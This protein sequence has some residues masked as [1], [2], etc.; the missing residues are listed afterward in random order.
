MIVSEKEISELSRG[1]KAQLLQWLVKD[2][3]GNFAF[4]LD[5]GNA[6]RARRIAGKLRGNNFNKKDF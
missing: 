6:V 3:G 2:L 4:V 5:A 1:E